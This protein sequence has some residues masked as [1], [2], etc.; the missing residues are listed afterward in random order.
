ML[1]LCYVIESAGGLSVN[2][3]GNDGF[4]SIANWN[5]RIH[6]CFVM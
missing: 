3:Q 4:W 5:G 1:L 2:V 6:A